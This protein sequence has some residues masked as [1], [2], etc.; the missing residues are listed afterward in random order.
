MQSYRRI[1]GIV[2]LLHSFLTLALGG[3]VW[4]VY[5]KVMNPHYPFHRRLFK[6]HNQSG[7]FKQEKNVFPFP[8]I[9]SRII[10]P[11]A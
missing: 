5:T 3:D 8:G 1:R 2:L 10:Q 4:A 7:C 6:P 11:I 9:E